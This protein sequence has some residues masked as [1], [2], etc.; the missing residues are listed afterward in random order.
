MFKVLG[1]LLGIALA[2]AALLFIAAWPTMYVLGLLHNSNGMSW[3]PAL[4]FWQT[5][6]SLF[7]VGSFGTAFNG[8]S[9]TTSTSK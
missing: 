1:V 3:V 9:H 8:A 5:L 2:I 4:G 6:G 7:V